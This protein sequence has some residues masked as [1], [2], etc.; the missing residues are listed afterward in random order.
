MSSCY[1]LLSVGGRARSS[2]AAL[3]SCS[4]TVTSLS[5]S[6]S[7]RHDRVTS[8]SPPPGPAPPFPNTLPLPMLLINLRVSLGLWH[9]TAGVL[10]YILPLFRAPSR[11]QGKIQGRE[12][13]GPETKEHGGGQ[14]TDGL[15]RQGEHRHHPARRKHWPCRW[16]GSC[17]RRGYPE[18]CECKD[19]CGE[20]AKLLTVPPPS[21]RVSL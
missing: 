10:S 20:T 8:P 9:S 16:L 7:S 6:L 14:Q 5:L 18:P 19:R 21:D 11:T 2:D 12:Q 4:L 17:V 13:S 15:L 1:C 3:S